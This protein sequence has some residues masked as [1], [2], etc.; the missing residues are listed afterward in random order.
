LNAAAAMV[1]LVV[2]IDSVQQLVQAGVEGVRG[3]FG[4]ILGSDPELALI[5]SPTLSYSHGTGLRVEGL[6]G[7]LV[8][9]E[10]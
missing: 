4:D 5:V 3:G 10:G 1:Y 9:L 7:P 6:A 2:E 8:H